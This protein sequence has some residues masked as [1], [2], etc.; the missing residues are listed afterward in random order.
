MHEF[1]DCSWMIILYPELK[2]SFILPLAYYIA[3]SSSAVYSLGI[4]NGTNKTHWFA[5]F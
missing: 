4:L 1:K 5:S 2:E 3:Q